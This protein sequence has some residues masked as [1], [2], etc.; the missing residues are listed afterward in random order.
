MAQR[1]IVYRESRPWG[2]FEQFT[3]NALSTVKLIHV[4]PGEALSLQRHHSR[5]EF[6][7][8]ISG[9]GTLTIGDL[10]IKAEPGTDHFVPRETNHR[11][12]GGSEPLL[13]LEISTGEFDEN[14]IERLEDRYSRA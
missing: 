7:R 3:K 10:D 2:E 4:K 12:T 8:V 14:D 6:W 5:D 1:P 11:I 13:I 9:N